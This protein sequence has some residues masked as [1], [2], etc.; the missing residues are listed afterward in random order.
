MANAVLYNQGSHPTG[1]LKSG[2][3]SM[4]VS[5]SLDIGA[6]KWRNGYENNNMWVIYSDTY[7]Q[8]QATQGNSLPTIWATSTFTDSGLVNLI[9]TLPKSRSNTIYR[10]NSNILVKRSRCLFFI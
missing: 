4:N 2:T 5:P 9:N 7:S 3:M 1:A 8:G 6:L 10:C